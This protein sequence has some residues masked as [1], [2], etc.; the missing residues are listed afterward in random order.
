MIVHID[1]TQKRGGVKLHGSS[2]PP[3]WDVSLRE[4]DLGGECGFQYKFTNHFYDIIL[5][6]V[7]YNSESHRAKYGLGESLPMRVFQ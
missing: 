2:S 1:K 3:L 6:E 5:N 4:G 7:Y